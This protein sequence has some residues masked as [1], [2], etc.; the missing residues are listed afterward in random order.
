MSRTTPLAWKNLVHEPRRLAVSVAGV[1]F[2]VL[3]IFMQL[4]FLNALLESTVQVLRRLNGELIVLS[5]ARYAL[6]ARDRFDRRRLY[7]IEGLPNIQGVYPLYMETVDSVLR[8]QGQRGLPIRVLAWREDQPTFNVHWLEG[9]LEHLRRPGTAAFDRASRPKYGFHSIQD[10]PE[11]Y[12]AELAGKRLRLGG[13]FFLGIDFATDGNLIMLARNFAEFFPYRSESGDPLDM[14]DLAVIELAPGADARS[15]QRQLSALLPPDVQVMTKEALIAREKA[16][17]RSNAPVGY[18]F[19]VGVCVG[20]LVGVVIC[21][22][23]IYSDIADHLREFATLKA[24]GY[25]TRYFLK[26][27]LAQGF[28]LSV[29]GFVPSLLAAAV[30][31]QSLAH[32]TGLTMQL[33]WPVVGLVFGVTLLMCSVSGLLAQRR[34]LTLDPADLF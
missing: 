9:G 29:L 24:M 12:A 11:S 14:V 27:A 10:V 23:I 4:G 31:Y 17:W 26:L 32:Y 33:T 28:Y 3:L 19:L 30:F 20:F 13:S 15:V 8:P 16:F 22:Q 2:A 7:Q 5:R 21:Y 25:T 6:P 34:L 1:G 18:I